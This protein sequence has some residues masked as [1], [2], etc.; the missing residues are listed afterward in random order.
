MTDRRM[1]KSDEAIRA[2]FLRLLFSVRYETISM[3]RV[4]AEADVSRS[5]LYQHY[6]TRERILEATMA[7]IIDDLASALAGDFCSIDIDPTLAHFWDNRRL[8]RVVFGPPID[9]Q[10]RRWLAEAIEHKLVA[11]GRS[12]ALARIAAIQSAAGAISLLDQWMTGHLDVP[13]SDIAT[14]LVGRALS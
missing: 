1:R 9:A 6:P 5:T 2:A 3:S 12:V 14:A 4:A 11:R 10:V 8:S 7:R 13:R